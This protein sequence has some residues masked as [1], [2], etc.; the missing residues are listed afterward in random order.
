MLVVRGEVHEAGLFCPQYRLVATVS[1][2][3]G[4][5]ELLIEDEGKTIRDIFV[6]FDEDGGGTIDHEE[7]REVAVRERER[8][9]ERL[10]A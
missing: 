8:D 10:G 1:T 5:N 3:V 9:H 6:A 4:S 7:F 2:H